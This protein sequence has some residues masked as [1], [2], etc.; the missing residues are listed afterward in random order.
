[1]YILKKVPKIKKTLFFPLRLPSMT[2]LLKQKPIELKSLLSPFWKLG[3]LPMM[4]FCMFG[5][6]IL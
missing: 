1:M 3:M 5:L 6:F 4:L 2:L